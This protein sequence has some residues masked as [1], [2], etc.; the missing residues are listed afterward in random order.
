DVRR[1]CDPLRIAVNAATRVDHLRE[2]AVRA[3]PAHDEITCAA[4]GF[5]IAFVA[6]PAIADDQGGDAPCRIVRKK[7]LDLFPAT[8]VLINRPIQRTTGDLMFQNALK[9]GP[10]IPDR[11]A[12]VIGQCGEQKE[13]FTQRGGL[14]RDKGGMIQTVMENSTTPQLLDKVAVDVLL[15][16]TK[17]RF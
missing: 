6:G 12:F 13:R 11:V 4:G 8:A 17:P 9:C 14:I 7:P 16:G 5:Q 2:T 15:R 3:A 1:A 10:R